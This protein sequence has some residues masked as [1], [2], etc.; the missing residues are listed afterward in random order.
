ELNPSYVTAHRWY[1]H[2]LSNLGR[3]EESAAEMRKARLVDPLSP[4]IHGLSG[5]L[6]YQARD[7]DRALEHLQNALALNSN[8]WVLHTWLARIYERKG[9]LEEAMR[10]FQ[11]AFD[12][13]GGNMETISLK[14][15]IHAKSGNRAEAEKAIRVL[16]ELSAQKYVPPY[17]IAMVYAGLNEVESVLCWLEKAYET[18]DVRLTF[19]AVEPKWD[20]M[21]G[22][23]Q[24]L[25]LLGRLA[26]PAKIEGG[27]AAGGDNAGAVK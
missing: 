5:H 12:L 13:S 7:Y 22:H 10:E 17:N 4:I 14:G 27:A 26:L 1:G 18:R 11:E 6:R 20:F 24:F 8:L 9:M 16:T 15:Y 25:D 19:L 3:H 23:P 2:L 21:R